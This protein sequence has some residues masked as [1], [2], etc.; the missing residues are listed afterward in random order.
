[1]RNHF[2]SHE[3]LKR[4]EKRVR[5]WLRFAA[6]D[7]FFSGPRCYD[8][9]VT[10]ALGTAR[11]DPTH[12]KPLSASPRSPRS[13]P[14]PSSSAI[15]RGTEHARARGPNASKFL[16]VSQPTREAHVA[17]QRLGETRQGLRRKNSQDLAPGHT[18]SAI[19]AGE[20]EARP[21]SAHLSGAT[22]STAARQRSDTGSVIY[23]ATIPAG[24]VRRGSWPATPRGVS[25]RMPC[26]PDGHPT[27]PGTH[28]GD[29][30]AAMPSASCPSRNPIV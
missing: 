7:I 19:R 28:R 6:A 20:R 12:G 15:R 16:R 5:L 14:R 24:A 27:D 9:A 23:A 11:R 2:A 30:R 4:L 17:R 10:G 22:P 26:Q 29:A 3:T 8:F 25:A 1:M 18:A 21:V 13:G